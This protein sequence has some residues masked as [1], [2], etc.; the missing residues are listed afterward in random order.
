MEGVDVQVLRQ[1]SRWRGA[2][3]RAALVTVLTTYGSAPRPPGALLAIRADGLLA[4]SVSGGCVEAELIAQL[5]SH[6]PATPQVLRF[7]GTP[8]ENQRLQLPCKGGMQLL[9]EPQPEP[10]WIDALLEKL[11][12]RQP[13]LR[14]VDSLSGQVRLL[15]AEGGSDFDWDGR[16]LRV[17]H[18]PRWRLILIGA[19]QLS[20]YLAQMAQALDYEIIVCDPRAEY[21]GGWDVAGTQL[22]SAMP[23]DLLRLLAPDARTAVIALTHDPRLDDLALLEALL[24]DA[25]YVGAL[26]SVASNARRRARLL[27]M[28]LPAAAIARLHGPVGLPIGSRTPPEIAIA[29]LAELTALRHGRRPATVPEASSPSSF[30]LAAQV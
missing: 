16:L 28:D 20:H 27:E 4:G 24:S 2:G 26:G 25:F 15:P 11:D 12:R 7:G 10:A 19:G 13:V 6:W 14:E 21:A 22:S 5:Q 17:M 8:A 9:L 1:I 30:P 23:D 18:G 29:I 3:E